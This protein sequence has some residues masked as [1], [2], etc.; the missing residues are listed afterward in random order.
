MTAAFH[1]FHERYRRSRTSSP[2]KYG[3]SCTPMVLTYGVFSSAGTATFRSR[4]RLSMLS[5][6]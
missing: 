6:T 3:S 1:R 4:A 2:G 5:I